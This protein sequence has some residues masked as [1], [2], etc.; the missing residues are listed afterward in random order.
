MSV[1]NRK[2]LVLNKNWIALGTITVKR[3]IIMLFTTY[4]TGEPK[5]K[6]VETND[7]LNKFSTYDWH[8]WSL[9]KPKNQDSKIFGVNGEFRVPEVI[10]LTKND[11]IPQDKIRFS[12]RAIFK[13]D[14]YTCGYCGIRFGTEI[15]TWDHIIPKSAPYYGKTD[16]NNIITC[17][18]NCNQKKKNRTPEKANMKLLKQPIKPK[19]NLFDD[20]VKIESWKDF[21][22]E[23]YWEIEIENDNI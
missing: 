7:L 2:V 3:A 8:Q 6:V 22:S 21:L 12:R 1:L 10:L 13:R 4:R 16:W 18:V 20:K 23:M 17:C 19:F 11:K 14:N 5:A 9:M 15:L